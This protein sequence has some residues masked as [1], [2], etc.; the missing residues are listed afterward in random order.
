MRSQL[1]PASHGLVGPSATD[2][3]VAMH[4][5]LRGHLHGCLDS[6]AACSPRLLLDLGAVSQGRGPGS[7]GGPPAAPAAGKCPPNHPA[8]LASFSALRPSAHGRYGWPASLPPRGANCAAWP[9]SSHRGCR[10]SQS[11]HWALGAECWPAAF[12]RE[13]PAA[14]SPSGP[15]LSGRWSHRGGPGS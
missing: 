15:A 5:T 7:R 11:G 8:T 6:A 3:H 1:L 9:G 2:G 12:W 13:P 14:S 10:S 4:P